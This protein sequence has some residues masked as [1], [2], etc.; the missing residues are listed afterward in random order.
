MVLINL[1]AEQQMEIKTLRTDLWTWLRGEGESGRYGENNMETYILKCKI[2][3]R[4]EFA[5]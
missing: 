5:L 3:S 2:D 4:R 1:F